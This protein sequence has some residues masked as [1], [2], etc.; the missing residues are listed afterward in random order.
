M[1][2]VQQVLA[3][4]RFN[5]SL[6]VEVRD[7]RLTDGAG[8]VLVREVLERC[9]VR[10]RLEQR[11]VDRRERRAVTHPLAEL[12][13]TRVALLALGWRD[14]DDAD[15]LRDDPALRLAVSDRA[16][17]LPLR[18][19]GD[20][21]RVPDGLASQPTLSR[22]TSALGT[23]EN[24]AT[25]GDAVFELAVARLLGANG[26][27]RYKRLTID[28]DGMPIEV[29]GHQ[30]GATYNGHYRA[31]IFHPLLAVCG[32]TGDLLGALLRKGTAHAAEDFGTFVTGLVAGLVGRVCQSVLVRI[33]A[34]MVSEKTLALL[35]RERIPYIARVRNHAWFDRAAAPH[36]KR[37]VGRRPLEPREF[38]HELT[39][40]PPAWSRA[41]RMT[42]VVQERADDLYLHHFWLVT[43]LDPRAR[44]TADLL[45]AYRRRGC[46]ESHLGELSDVLAPALS[47]S[48][49]G[50]F[51]FRT[52]G[53]RPEDSPDFRAN[54]VTFQLNLLA[55]NAMHALRCLAPPG[56]DDVRINLRTLRERVLRVAG[57]FLLHARRVIVSVSGPAARLWSAIGSRLGELD[58][59]A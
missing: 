17:D 51:S 19:A 5:R 47:S 45:A 34:G 2:E 57:R 41:R 1:G 44:D 42:L 49:R 25:L 59:P 35:E 30:S 6:K 4:M 53:E 23:A 43:S 58:A 3:G 15:L 12:V 24:L 20:G 21:A 40:Q 39:L 10:R 36:L 50:D 52:D 32:E 8:A 46:A 28:V 56:V 33:D 18:P 29:E 55:Y 16:G 37:P 38:L 11:L 27:R 26:G 7:E 13:T 14:Q 22:M 48:T 54:A 31:T 9:G